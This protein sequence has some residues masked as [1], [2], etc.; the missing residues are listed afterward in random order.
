[1]NISKE[2]NE[3]VGADVASVQYFPKGHLFASSVAL[4]VPT[5]QKYPGSVVG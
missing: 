3:P 5:S 1:M 4:I 2:I